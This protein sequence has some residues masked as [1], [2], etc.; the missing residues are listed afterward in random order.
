MIL[1][2]VTFGQPVKVFA[3]TLS[4]SLSFDFVYL[5]QLHR[6][7]RFILYL[8]EL[9]LHCF[10]YGDCKGILRFYNTYNE[11]VCVMVFFIDIPSVALRQ[12]VITLYVLSRLFI[13]MYCFSITFR[14]T[15]IKVTVHMKNYVFVLLFGKVNK[16]LFINKKKHSTLLVSCWS[17]SAKVLAGCRNLV[18]LG[19]SCEILTGTLWYDHCAGFLLS[20]WRLRCL[21]AICDVALEVQL[22]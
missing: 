5:N 20:P 12:K 18:D 22:T 17:T 15:G 7:L 13:K 21:P 9:T 19:T 4:V 11:Y 3:C 1:S 8:F 2:F 10:I 6:H 16:T 14:F